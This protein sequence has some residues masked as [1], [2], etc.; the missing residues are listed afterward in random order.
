M[1][2]QELISTIENGLMQYIGAFMSHCKQESEAGTAHMA[3]AKLSEA[4]LKTCRNQDGSYNMFAAKPILRASSVLLKSYEG[5]LLKELSE[6]GMNTKPVKDK[7]DETI[8][9]IN[10]LVNEIKE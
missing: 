4:W 6:A 8:D 2:D 7:L 9:T 5:T 10:M 3:L 1:A